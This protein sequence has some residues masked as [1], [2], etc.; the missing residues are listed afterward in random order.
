MFERSPRPSSVCEGRLIAG[1]DLVPAETACR[2]L[3]WPLASDADEFPR[4]RPRSCSRAL[5]ERRGWVV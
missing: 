3:P 1:A 5:D 4:T 2:L